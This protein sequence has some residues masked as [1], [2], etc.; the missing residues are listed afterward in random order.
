MNKYVYIYIWIN[1]KIY[2]YI[3]IYLFIILYL[4][5]MHLYTVYV[6]IFYCR[7]DPWKCLVWWHVERTLYLGLA[8]K[9]RYG[10][11][12]GDPDLHVRDGSSGMGRTAVAPGDQ[13]HV[14]I[15][16]QTWITVESHN[17]R[18]SE[19]CEISQ[20][21]WDLMVKASEC[22]Q[23]MV[24]TGFQYTLYVCMYVCMY[25]YILNIFKFAFTQR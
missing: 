20:E 4:Y 15:D 21:T 13:G 9:E 18:C 5:I 3:Y 8:Q 22:H 23:A 24:V 14:A 2:I 6:S 12:P 19:M 11:L 25:I 1:F 7:L 17:Q 16:V 10:L